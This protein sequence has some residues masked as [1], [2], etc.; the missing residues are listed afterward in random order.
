MKNKILRLYDA[1]YKYYGPQYW[2]PAKTKFEVIVGAILTQNTSWRNVEKAVC[3][4]RKAKLLNPAAMKD[5]NKK[6]LAALIMP[7]GC[8]NIKAGRLKS[9][10]NFLFRKYGGS[11]KRMFSQDTAILRKELLEVKGLGFETVDSILLYAGQKPVFV[12]DAYTKRILANHKLISSGDKYH[13][14]QRLFMESLPSDSALFNEYHALLVRLA[15]EACTTHPKCEACPV[16]SVL[17]SPAAT[18]RYAPF[19]VRRHPPKPNLPAGR[20]AR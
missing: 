3:N 12:V 8:Y 15:K 13:E 18:P 20:Q 7:S 6:N 10:I 1:L 2:W 5:I 14:V 9:F 4:L 19:R 16:R 17:W 11:L